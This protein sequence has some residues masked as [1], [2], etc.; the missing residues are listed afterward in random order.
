[1]KFNISLDNAV[2]YKGCKIVEVGG[3]ST[4]ETPPEEAANIV[5]KNA[6]A[7]INEIPSVD[8]GEITLTGAMALWA[9]LI[10]FHAVVHKFDKVYYEDGRGQKVL[11]AQH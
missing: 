10:V 11:I 6:I 1:M 8:R 7:L 5:G 2:L 9:Y 4:L 3:K